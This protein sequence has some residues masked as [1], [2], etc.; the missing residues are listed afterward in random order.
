MDKHHQASE[1]SPESGEFDD[2]PDVPAH[3]YGP[4]S[5]S[6]D[7]EFEFQRNE[8][9]GELNPFANEF[10]SVSGPA[11]EQVAPVVLAKVETD[12]VASTF[13]TEEAPAPKAVR[14]R[15]PRIKLVEDRVAARP[16]DRLTDYKSSY[17]ARHLD[18]LEA[19]A[20]AGETLVQVLAAEERLAGG[21]KALLERSEQLVERAERAEAAFE[22]AKDLLGQQAKL[23]ASAFRDQ[24]TKTELDGH[25]TLFGHLLEVSDRVANSTTKALNDAA[26]GAGE[27]AGFKA[28]AAALKRI[29]DTVI[30]EAQK[31][32]LEPAVRAIVVASGRIETAVERIETSPT[33]QPAAADAAPVQQPQQAMPEGVG[34]LPLLLMWTRHHLGTPGLFIGLAAAGVGLCKFFG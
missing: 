7:S 32:G 15:T 3:A 6:A 29:T 33:S 34:A 31:A 20:R 12:A 4:S 10:V 14:T 9:G 28:E 2:F 18:V 8:S 19:E 17:V 30:A 26:D 25:A 24:L 16:L 1:Y 13:G 5:D 22:L 27:V 21:L 11:A 23:I